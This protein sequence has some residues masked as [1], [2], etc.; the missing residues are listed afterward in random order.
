ML[1]QAVRRSRR[2]GKSI[3]LGYEMWK[4]VFYVQSVDIIFA[5][6]K[7]GHVIDGMPYILV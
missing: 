3:D 5:L 4:Y 7:K 1:L 6:S 2:Y